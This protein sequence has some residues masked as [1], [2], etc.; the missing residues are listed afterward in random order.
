MRTPPHAHAPAPS[1]SEKKEHASSYFLFCFLILPT[2]ALQLAK[3]SGFN[4]IIT[5]SSPATTAYCRAAGATH[6][7]DYHTTPYA[8]LASLIRSSITDKAISTVYDAV[9]KPDSQPACWSVLGPGGKL[10]ITLPP[11]AGVGGK[12]G[13]GEEDEEGKRVVWVHGV[14]ADEE[15]G[16]GR[17]ARGLFGALE[18]L[19]ER[20]ELRPNRVEVL[21]GGLGAVREALGRFGSGKV[22]GV[23]LVVRVGDTEW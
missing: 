2:P 23:K 10:V 9:S 7:I 3:L 18:G 14:A 16:D 4:P 6:V 12:L 11:A 8:A 5:T 21:G 1:T 20:G 13:L 22:R 15:L 19:L 17:L